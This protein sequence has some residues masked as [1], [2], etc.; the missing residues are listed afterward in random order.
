MNPEISDFQAYQ[1][2]ITRLTREIAATAD[3]L[4]FW[5]HQATWYFH[6]YDTDKMTPSDKHLEK[7]RK[8][9]EEYYQKEKEGG[10]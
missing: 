6:F 2:E 10:W 8:T 5:K 7:Y 9:L 1:N 4:A 3:E